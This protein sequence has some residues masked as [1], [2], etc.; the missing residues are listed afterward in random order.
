MNNHRTIAIDIGNSA[1]NLAL[2]E[3]G[4]LVNDDFFPSLPEFSGKI[5]HWI[6][7]RHPG[8]THVVIG[9]VVPSLGE[10]VKKTLI[11]CF[12]IHPF[13]VEDCK[14]ELLPLRVDQPET[15]GV[16][17]I[18]NCYAAIHFYGTP[19][20]VVSLGTATT[21]EAISS[22]GEYLGGAIAPGLKISLEALSQ[23]TALLPAAVLEKPQ[24]IIAKNT[25]DHMKSGLYYGTL[26][27]IE[28]MTGRFK[29]T[30]GDSTKVIGTGGISALFTDEEIFD[31][32]DLTLTLKGLELIH[33]HRCQQ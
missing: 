27:M 29:Q 6:E 19:A 11:D 7:S 25:S 33:R 30:L 13:M 14:T 8:I 10:L 26:G 22:E 28:G 18:V 9:S 24:T 4:K 12:G 32:H 2:F 23:R 21:F 31:H 16:D 20:I 17:R 5:R 1:T 15:V 3:D